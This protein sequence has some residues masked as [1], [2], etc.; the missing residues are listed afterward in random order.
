M[1]DY[2]GFK[3]CLTGLLAATMSACGA[4]QDGGGDAQLDEVDSTSQEAL[5]TITPYGPEWQNTPYCNWGD[6]GDVSLNTDSQ[7]QLPVKV[8]YDLFA[9]LQYYYMVNATLLNQ[10]G[11][12]CN[13]DLQ[14]AYWPKGVDPHLSPTATVF[15]SYVSDKKLVPEAVSSGKI[16]DC[17]PG[18]GGTVSISIMPTPNM[19]F[20]TPS[21]S[22]PVISYYT[23]N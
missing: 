15:R 7:K 5:Y 8:Y 12:I 2:K 14:W 1:N 23:C 19:M 4:A 3:S 16:G 21:G 11:R 20:L 9:G 17:V 18:N 10:R 13:L 22:H 6:L